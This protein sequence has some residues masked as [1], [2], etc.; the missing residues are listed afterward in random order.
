MLPTIEGIYRNGRVELLETPLPRRQT[1]VIVTFL[2]DLPKPEGQR[3][4]LANLGEI[5][6]DD[7]AAAS[8]E[9]AV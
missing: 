3:P 9:I 2:D 5:L 1:R 8:R 7:L 4:S 6:T